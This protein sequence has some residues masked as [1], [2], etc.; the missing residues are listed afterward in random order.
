MLTNNNIMLCV[1]KKII[2]V[3]EIHILPNL[4]CTQ[5]MIPTSKNNSNQITKHRQHNITYIY[6]RRCSTILMRRIVSIRPPSQIARN[7]LSTL[8][9]K[10]S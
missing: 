7:S 10:S 9:E 6:F 8:L 2:Y 5:N 4:V 3:L 1:L